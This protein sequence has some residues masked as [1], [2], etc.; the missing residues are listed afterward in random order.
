MPLKVSYADLPPDSVIICPSCGARNFRTDN[1]CR[2]C[3]SSLDDVKLSMAKGGMKRV[4]EIIN[5]YPSLKERI[6]TKLNLSELPPD[7]VYVQGEAM[8]VIESWGRKAEL[9]RH[10]ENAGNYDSA[11]RQYEDMELWAEAKTLRDKESHTV[12]EKVVLVKCR[13]CGSLCP[14]GTLKCS[15]CGGAL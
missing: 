8:D 1:F 4:R 9:S 12:I 5:L 7:D 2:G 10:L 11:A 3:D 6:L 13:Y 15:S 14:Q